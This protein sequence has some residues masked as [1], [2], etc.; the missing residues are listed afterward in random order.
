VSVRTRL[1]LTL[2]LAAVPLVLALVAFAR[3]AQR[4]ALVEA[5]T[6]TTLER[7]ADGGSERCARRADRRG[8]R[9][10]GPRRRGFRAYG[11]DLEPA[12]PATPPL[13]PSLR[14]VLAGGADRAV[15]WQGRR[16]VLALRVPEGGP[17]AVVRVE[18]RVD[19]ALRSGGLVAP[20]LLAVGA[21]SLTALIALLALGPVVRRLRRLAEAVAERSGY[22]E[23][24]AVEGRDEVAELARAFNAGSAEVRRRMQELEQRDEALRDYLSRTTHDV[25]VPLTV[26][27]GHLAALRDQG[28]APPGPLRGAL[29]EAH[30]LGNLLRNL[31]A[32]ARLEV[33]EPQVSR[34]PIDLREV[35]ERVVS[36]HRPLAR[37]AEVSLD[38]AVPEGPVTV[39]ADSTLAEQAASNLVQN[40][41]RYNRAGGHVAVLL[42]ATGDAFE[43]AVLDDGP[44]I[45][46]AEL[47]RVTQRAFRGGEARQRQPGGLGLGLHI[48]RDV[49]AR[50]GWRLSFE[51]P[52]EGGLRVRIAGQV[53]RVSSP[54]SAAADQD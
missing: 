21:V 54:I 27:Q 38:Y 1:A 9:V 17:C 40:A 13:E 36:R 44:G 48:V 8:R 23:D 28:D 14:D 26:L 2:A 45:P 29:E 47:A 46:A 30:Y 53:A 35:V 3:Q 15:R 32:V 51:A 20:F 12:F 11:E 4:G 24:V 49:A 22:A 37:E 5:L 42:E 43:L 16:L 52:E 6:E 33:G 19:L 18:R 50:H 10:R 34:H 41:V 7:M 39:E 31:N 25:M